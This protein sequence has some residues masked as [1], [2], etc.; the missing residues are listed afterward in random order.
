MNITTKEKYLIVTLQGSE[1]IYS[2]RRKIYLDID[3][4]NSVKWYKELIPWSS[5]Q[6]RAP[7]TYLPGLI[8]SGSFLT[9]NGWDFVYVERPKGWTRPTLQNVLVIRT[10]RNRYRRIILNMS[11][12]EAKVLIKKLIKK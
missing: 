12:Q 3:S 6:V 10:Q 2:L 5:W 11:E 1:I 7:G 4:I 8:M 9:R